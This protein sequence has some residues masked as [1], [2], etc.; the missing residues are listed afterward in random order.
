M[1]FNLI[2]LVII[3]SIFLSSQLFKRRALI[4]CGIC[5]AMIG[6][7]FWWG[8]YMMAAPDM[9]HSMVLLCNYPP[10]PLVIFLALYRDW[11]FKVHWHKIT[12][13]IGISGYTLICF[14]NLVWM[15]AFEWS[16]LN[17]WVGLLANTLVFGGCMWLILTHKS[18]CLWPQFNWGFRTE[19]L[20]LVASYLAFTG[21]FLSASDR[22]IDYFPIIFSMLYICYLGPYLVRSPLQTV[23]L[24][25]QAIV[26]SST[27]LGISLLVVR[28]GP[29]LAGENISFLVII[30]GL[31]ITPVVLIGVLTGV[32]WLTTWLISRPPF[33][34]INV[35]VY[36]F[37][38]NRMTH[39]RTLQ[40]F[41]H[42]L[43]KNFLFRLKSHHLYVWDVHHSNM[44]GL[45][46]NMPSLSFEIVSFI[47][48]LNRIHLDDLVHLMKKYE[49]TIFHKNIHLLAQF[50]YDND[51]IQ[52]QL[53]QHENNIVGMMAVVTTDGRKE[54]LF[55][56]QERLLCIGNKI[57]SALSGIN[58]FQ[59]LVN[60]QSLLKR[61]NIAV[62][63]L[64]SNKC[65]TKNRQLAQDTLLS[66]MPEIGSYLF[67]NC[68]QSS[69]F[70]KCDHAFN[71]SSDHLNIKLHVSV[72][73][74]HLHENTSCKFDFNNDK[75]PLELKSIMKL[76]NSSFS[77]AIRVDDSENSSVIILFFSSPVDMLDYRIAFCQFFL[78][79]FEIFN[80]Y[81][82][83]CRYLLDLEA[84]LKSLLDQLPTAIMV[85]NPNQA[86]SYFNAKMMAYLPRMDEDELPLVGL[87]GL[88]API[89]N[90]ISYVQRYRSHQVSKIDIE[91]QG[92]PTLHRLM[93]FGVSFEYDWMTVIVLTDIQQSKDLIDQMNQTHRLAMMS[94]MSKGVSYELV[95]PV[96][97]LL[98]GLSRL[99]SE[100]H[101]SAFQDHFVEF[102]LPQIDRINLLCQSL[103]RL[104]RSNMEALDAVFIPDILN[105]VWRM[106]GHDL[107]VSKHKIY[108]TY[109]DQKTVFIDQIMLLQAVM[110]LILFSLNSIETDRGYLFIEIHVQPTRELV[111]KVGMSHVQPFINMTKADI[112]NHLELVVV[113][114]IVINQ[115]GS[116]AIHDQLPMRYFEVRLPVKI[117]NEPDTNDRV[118]LVAPGLA[119]QSS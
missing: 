85:V 114:Q 92:V 14:F 104:S 8:H 41:S 113:N 107:H 38:L 72:L 79:Q 58:A 29:F 19:T 77:L 91:Y 118:A 2:V 1:L 94:R 87:L 98:T 84:F 105:R 7:I 68:D 63:Q 35:P 22:L 17:E 23:Q 30:L 5:S 53:L 106:I 95:S 31:G 9:D 40:D 99:P 33:S 100:W 69:Q 108:V 13:L 103:L 54:I 119:T 21:V 44:T 64:N 111:I 50:M 51:I 6:A 42:I 52:V 55:S 102:V 78:R 86:V 18:V 67:L 83:S 109:I 89:T 36:D 43:S 116:L 27:V 45:L 70:Y 76:A 4:L 46:P 66:I 115:N 96:K 16:I 60:Y 73:A 57:A 26:W 62:R 47:Q 81:Q 15:Y 20:C 65:I 37:I 82:Y 34:M 117:F 97:Q 25:L 90:I 88:A 71:L 32:Q 101:Q 110:N 11:R 80:E 12:A 49:H 10:L 28:V 56:D 74:H 93:G 75:T 48:Y 24:Y 59:R 61:V 39:V 112:N 3:S